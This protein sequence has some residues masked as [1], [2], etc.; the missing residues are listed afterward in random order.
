[1]ENTPRAKDLWGPWSK[2]NLQITPGYGTLCAWQK[3]L[4]QLPFAATT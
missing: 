3:K 1:M 2:N 4:T